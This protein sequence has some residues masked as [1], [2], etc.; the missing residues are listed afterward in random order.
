MDI[1]EVKELIRRAIKSLQKIDSF[2]WNQKSAELIKN[3]IIYLLEK[4]L[5]K[6]K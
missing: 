3:E 5:R 2:N 4:A 1:K 6:L